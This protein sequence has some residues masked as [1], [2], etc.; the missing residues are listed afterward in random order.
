VTFDDGYRNN[1][2]HA[3]PLL[4][5]HGVPAVFN[6]TTGYIGTGQPLWTD[7]V[8][9]RIVSVQGDEVPLPDGSSVQRPGATSALLRLA[10]RARQLCK[11]VPDAQRRRYLATLRELSPYPVGADRERLAFL[12]WDEVRTLAR[13]G[14]E[15]GSHTVD[16]PILSRLRPEELAWQ[17]ATSRTTVER[18]TGRP[19]TCIAY[20]N[21]EPADIPGDIEHAARRAGY[22]M[23]L[24]I[25][26]RLHR[27]GTSD[28]AVGRISVP[29]H[30]PRDVF[31]AR[32]S[33][34]HARL[35][36]LPWQ[37]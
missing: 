28:F 2:T 21:G 34:I 8:V 24:T 10:H 18:E 3:A 7:E 9:E 4:Q 30:V 19:C 25:S 20:P 36:G 31:H 13:R 11:R 16:H 22:R 15:I 33:G 12:T 1:L 29:G 17:L 26:N 27:L 32:I 23:G 5:R 6:V 35:Q 14:F 37:S